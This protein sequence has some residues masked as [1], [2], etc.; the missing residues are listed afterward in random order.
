MTARALTIRNKSGLHA[1]PATLFVQTAVHFKSKIK[2]TCEGRMVDAKS[3]LG[4]LSLGAGK[5]SVIQ[6]E[7]EGPDET[8][9]LDALET[10]LKTTIG[11]EE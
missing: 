6:V 2:V 8:A 7:A 9:A 3:I 10:L 1:R 11:E 4:I 5:N